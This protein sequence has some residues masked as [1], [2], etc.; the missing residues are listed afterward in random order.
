VR[1]TEAEARAAAQRLVSKLDDV[2]GTEIR[3]RALDATTLGVALQ[4][5][6]REHSDADGYVEPYVWTGI[7]RARS[8]CGAALVGDPDQIVAKIERYMEMGMRAFIFSGYPH[9]DE[10]KLFAEYVLPKLKT[11]SLPQELGR[12]PVSVPQTP[13]GAGERR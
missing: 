1:E 3:N 8:G 2:F 11:V 9:L 10:C 13:L 4:A 5:Q 7:G 12:I 6:T